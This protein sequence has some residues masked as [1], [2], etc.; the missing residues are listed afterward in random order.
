[1]SPASPTPRRYPNKPFPF[2]AA[3]DFSFRPETYWP[4]LPTEE[5]VLA[6]VKG[7]TRREAAAALLDEPSEMGEEG[8]DFLLKPG[9]EEEERDLWGSVHPANLGGEFLPEPEDDEVEIA[10][11]ELMSTTGDVYQVPARRG[12]DGLIQFRVVDDY[13]DEGSRHRLAIERS[14]QPLT[15]GELIELI[16]TERQDNAGWRRGDESDD[17][18]LFDR[19]REAS[20]VGTADPSSLVD[21]ATASSAFYPTL[22]DYYEDRAGAWLED[23]RDRLAREA[24]G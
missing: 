5:T 22:T 21:F 23:V 19:D 6:Q 3:Y 17:L 16:D 9:L 1:M 7:T 18:G 2:D 15:M 14:E 13:W 10:R 11:I 12:D 24:E 8:A 20:L 4:E